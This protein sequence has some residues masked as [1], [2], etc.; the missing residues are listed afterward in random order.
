MK[1]FCKPLI[2]IALTITLLGSTGCGVRIDTPDGRLPTLNY[3]QTARLQTSLCLEWGLKSA[4]KTLD[5]PKDYWNSQLE[6]LG[7]PDLGWSST[8]IKQ[9]N[10]PLPPGPES[11]PD[12]MKTLHTL[13]SCGAQTIA[14]AEHLAAAID[15]ASASEIDPKANTQTK[16]DNSQEETHNQQNLSR[17]LFSIGI[18]L[19][20]KAKTIAAA[21]N[22]S[23]KE[24]KTAGPRIYQYQDKH[25]GLKKD[26]EYRP[27]ADGKQESL[28]SL[29]LAIDKQR[30]ETE[31][32]LSVTN[33]EQLESRMS[34]YLNPL[35]LR[36]VDS[37]VKLYGHDPRL[38]GYR[39]D[40][41]P[42]GEA[43]KIYRDYLHTLLEIQFQILLKST[44]PERNRLSETAPTILQELEKEGEAIP[45]LPEIETKAVLLKKAATD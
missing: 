29:I 18:S 21:K 2:T 42:K 38:P 3:S 32:A 10:I 45:S 25:W 17:L 23:L 9:H 30:F 16:L 44:A 43:S 22:I 12:L 40:S 13:S 33:S 24:G 19:K 36:Q 37:L 26:T 14:D 31:M 39:S 11:S 5:I 7:K 1:N 20:A 34:R 28:K 41:L 8:S 4:G 27:S 35:V 15:F 6:A